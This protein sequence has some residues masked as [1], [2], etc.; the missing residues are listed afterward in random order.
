MGKRK[1]EHKE[2]VIAGTE[3]P[4]RTSPSKPKSPEPEAGAPQ[5]IVETFAKLH[6][7][8]GR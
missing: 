1:R 5:T 3:A 2:K 6:K 7:L 4:F 8:L